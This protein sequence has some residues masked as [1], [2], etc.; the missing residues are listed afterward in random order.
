MVKIG[1]DIKN[2]LWVIFN[3][4][5][6]FVVITIYALRFKHWE[7]PT[8]SLVNYYL[9]FLIALLAA[10]AFL[11]GRYN[12][13]IFLN[14]AIFAFVYVLGFIVIFTGKNYSFGSDY[15]QYYA[16]AYRKIIISFVTGLTIIFIPVDYL[17]HNKKA[18]IK[19]L[20]ALLL[21]LPIAVVYYKDFIVDYRYLFIA[22][23]LREIFLGFI[24]M[25]FW[26]LFFIIL[27]AYLM[28]KYDKPILGHVNL[29][30]FSFLVFL[31]I[32]SLD[33]F[34][35]YIKRPL[36]IFSGILLFLNL[37]LFVL[38]LLHNLIYI[39]S[40]FGQFYE[41]F[42][43]SEKK[44]GI[45]VLKRKTKIEKWMEY[46]SQNLEFSPYRL[47]FW[48]LMAF[49]I[50]L[51]LIF[52]PQSYERISFIILI[53]LT[54]AILLY[55]TRL[56]KKRAMDMQIMEEQKLSQFLEKEVNPKDGHLAKELDSGKN[57]EIE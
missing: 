33:N 44:L 56:M 39:S 26:A 20:I 24:G 43:F 41:Q 35:N 5:I 15:L 32:D 25:N 49:T 18:H 47:F 1:S 42:R 7:L 48:L 16:W 10:A 46:L 51:F 22:N 19:Y 31:S 2:Q 13:Y 53:G 9:Y 28:L 21:C 38:I 52:Y 40:D 3:I 54:A 50:G 14:I 36:P 34:F 27:Y 37:L 45:T 23:H 4:W 30:V 57:T 6:A 55:L 11:K 12:K 17:S 29:L 8:I